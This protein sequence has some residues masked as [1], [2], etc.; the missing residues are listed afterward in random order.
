LLR[1]SWIFDMNFPAT[2]GLVLKRDY[3][4]KILAKVPSSA[5]KN[6]IEGIIYR[7]VHEKAGTHHGASLKI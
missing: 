5:E 3:I 6:E 2:F 1:L 7:F 4:A